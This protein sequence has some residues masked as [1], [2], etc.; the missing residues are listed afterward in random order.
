[1]RIHRTDGRVQPRRSR[2]LDRFGV[3]KTRPPF[4]QH[5]AI[6]TRR[7]AVLLNAGATFGGDGMTKRSGRRRIDGVRLLGDLRSEHIEIVDLAEQPLHFSKTF[8]PLGR[9]LGQERLNGIAEALQSD[10][11]RVPRCGSIRAHGAC[12]QVAELLVA[13]ERQTLCG[14]AIRAYEA[15][16]RRRRVPK[17]FPSALIKL[18]HGAVYLIMRS[19]LTMLEHLQQPRSLRILGRRQ[20]FHP[21]LEHL[22]IPQCAQRTEQR[23]RKCP[24]RP[25]R[26]VTVDFRHHGGDGATAANG[27]SEVMDRF[28]FRG[29]P[30]TLKLLQDTVHTRS[31]PELRSTSRALRGL[32]GHLAP[33]CQFW[34]TRWF[35]ELSLP[36]VLLA[37]SVHLSPSFT[38]ERAGSA[39]RHVGG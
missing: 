15:S 29:S 37:R 23:A 26:L 11:N 21:R 33:P 30:D 4:A 14:E 35:R 3:R 20:L 17:T 16:S 9:P 31:Q 34:V 39:C 18:P 28:S 10:A 22:E 5:T 12:V 27:H 6:A 7:V 2:C 38:T 13:F 36:V 25:P 19:R 32:S 1:M 24:H 8:V